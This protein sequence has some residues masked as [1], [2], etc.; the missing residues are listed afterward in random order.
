MRA[1]GKRQTG[2][3]TGRCPVCGEPFR[4]SGGVIIPK[5]KARARFANPPAK[6]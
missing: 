3:I 5:H 2:S 1:T 4:L 6:P